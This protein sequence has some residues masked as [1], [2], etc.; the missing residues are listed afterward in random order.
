MV[1]KIVEEEIVIN[2][3]NIKKM[4]VSKSGQHC[5]LLT[6]HELF[7]NNYDSNQII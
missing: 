4:I 6:D 3:K 1:P 7:Y 5:L 2:R